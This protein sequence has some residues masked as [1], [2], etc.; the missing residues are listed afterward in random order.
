MAGKTGYTAI[1]KTEAGG[2][3]GVWSWALALSS[4]GKNKGAAW[5]FAQWATGK[6]IAAEVGKLTG[7]SP[8][9]SSYKDAA[10]TGSFNP[11]YLQVTTDS[12]ATA[13]TTAVLHDNWK[14]GAL[15]IVDA[16]LAIANGKDPKAA[17]SEANE[18]MTQ[19]I[20]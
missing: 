14:P 2:T 8:R 16:M 13:R 5:L 12:L 17:T 19:A 20:K 9:Q 11:E 15:V 10:Y 3:S 7:G 1:P 18:K 6:K 4:H